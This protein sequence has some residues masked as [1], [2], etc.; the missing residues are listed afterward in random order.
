MT[1]LEVTMWIV[2][3]L[4]FLVLVFFWNLLFHPIKTVKTSGEVLI[5]LT[6]FI[7]VLAAL[8]W[9]LQATGQV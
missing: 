9:L 7:L 4:G 3:I 1:K 2:G 8:G 5:K 6:I